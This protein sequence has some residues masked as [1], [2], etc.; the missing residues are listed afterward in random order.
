M[1][2]QIFCP[3]PQLIVRH[4]HFHYVYSVAYQLQI[5]GYV[6]DAAI[7]SVNT[8]RRVRHTTAVSHMYPCKR[9]QSVLTGE[10]ADKVIY[11]H[12]IR[13]IHAALQSALLRNSDPLL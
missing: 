3:P 9:A 12:V 2:H 7:Y 10:K 1:G 6:A 5:A 11:C 13:K 4:I 8:H